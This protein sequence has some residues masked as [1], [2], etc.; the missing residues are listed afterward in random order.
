MSSLFGPPSHVITAG[1]QISDQ[2]FEEIAQR[3][4]QRGIRT[5]I[6]NVVGYAQER[7]TTCVV[8]RVSS[9]QTTA[10][11]TSVPVVFDHIVYDPQKM[12]NG[13]SLVTPPVDGL[14]LVAGWVQTIANVTPS[15]I[16]VTFSGGASIA[17]ADFSSPT[18]MYATIAVYVRLAPTQPIQ[19]RIANSSGLSQDYLPSLGLM[20]ITR[21]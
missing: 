21:F 3:I 2:A 14:Y 16:F 1:N 4:E 20:L 17:G 19:L 12:W 6:A 7:N 15:D 13:T 9:A 18:G 5:P 10:T 11:G 8:N